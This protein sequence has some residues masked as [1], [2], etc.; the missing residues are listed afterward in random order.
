[1]VE[2]EKLRPWFHTCNNSHIHLC[3]KYPVVSILLC[4]ISPVL[5]LLPLQN[6]D[7]GKAAH[8]NDA[9]LCK[10]TAGLYLLLFG[11]AA[12][13]SNVQIVSAGLQ[14]R[15]PALRSC[16]CSSCSLC[17]PTLLGGIISSASLQ[18]LLVS[19]SAPQR[20]VFFSSSSC[21]CCTADVWSTKKTAERPV[22][23]ACF[24]SKGQKLDSHRYQ[25]GT[26]EVWLFSAWLSAKMSVS[27]LFPSAP[28]LMLQLNILPRVKKN[29]SEFAF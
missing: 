13:G 4:W 24:Q 28:R 21:F 23:P 14:E 27:A 25:G 3:S 20:G 19:L 10:T 7:F 16:L 9:G 8:V 5:R 29:Q 18:D 2:C 22:Y 26:G 15:Q 1:M 6:Y 17:C 12:Y 11:D